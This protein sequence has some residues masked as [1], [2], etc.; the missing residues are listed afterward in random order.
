MRVISNGNSFLILT[1]QS[2]EKFPTFPNFFTTFFKFFHIPFSLAENRFY[3]S[4][5]ETTDDNL[6]ELIV[7]EVGDSSLFY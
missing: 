4:E 3:R 6:H 7:G 5:T 1:L 2:Y